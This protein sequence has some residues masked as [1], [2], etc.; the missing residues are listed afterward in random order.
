MEHGASDRLKEIIWYMNGELIYGTSIH[1]S[2]INQF[3]EKLEYR[4]Y[5]ILTV[6]KEI[7]ELNLSVVK[8][9][10][11]VLGKLWKKE[12]YDW[13]RNLQIIID[14]FVDDFSVK[15]LYYFSFDLGYAHPLNQ[16]VKAKIRQILQQLRDENFIV[17]KSS[18]VYAKKSKVIED[19]NSMKTKTAE[20]DD[21]YDLDKLI[22]SS[23]FI[24]ELS[25]IKEE[26]NFELNKQY[27][28]SYQE[29]EDDIQ[30]LENVYLANQKLVWKIAKQY[31]YL[32]SPGLSI[33]DMFMEGILG[34]K[35]Q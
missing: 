24:K 15:D 31:S 35:K 26:P 20:I 17:S 13:K 11:P 29:N 10:E 4:Y 34:L 32:K 16:N 14:G 19:V 12:E 33:D 7:D 3:I 18:S 22:N 30:A 21:E 25:N 1:Q 23:K 27:I 28:S 5:G 6:Y 2:K 9:E 8:D